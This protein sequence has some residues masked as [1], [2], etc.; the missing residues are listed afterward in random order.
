MPKSN[1]NLFE[2]ANLIF[3]NETIIRNS[4]AHQVKCFIKD[5]EI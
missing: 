5:T 4:F 1:S 2:I 3:L